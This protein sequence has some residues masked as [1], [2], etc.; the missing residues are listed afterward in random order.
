MRIAKLVAQY[1]DLPLGTVD[2]LVN[3]A[4]ERLGTSNVATVDWRHFTVVKS[5]IGILN[6][7]P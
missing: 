2:A 3:A 1:K 4:A 5:K 7:L 6:L